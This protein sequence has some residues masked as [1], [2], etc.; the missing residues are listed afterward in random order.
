MHETQEMRFQSLVGNGNHTSILAWKT[1]R[2]K[3]P[4]SPRHCMESDTTQPLSACAH[5]HVR[6]H[7]CTHAHTHVEVG[8]LKN[9][10]KASQEV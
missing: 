10:L 8:E 4:D 1:L 3:E 7:T 9:Y 6:V 2:T 5:V